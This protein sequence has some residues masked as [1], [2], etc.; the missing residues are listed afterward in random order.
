MNIITGLKITTVYL[1]L[2]LVVPALTVLGLT[3]LNRNSKQRLAQRFGVRSIIYVGGLGVIVHELSHLL[4]AILFGHHIDNFR[5]LITDVQGSNGALGYVNHSWNKKNYYQFMGNTL[6]GTAPIFGC[7]IVLLLLTRFLVPGIYQ[8]GVQYMANLL[9]L[10]FS[11]SIAVGPI[12]WL[13]IILWVILSINVTIGGFDLSDAD[14]KGTVP[15]FVT[16]F[17]ITGV[18]LFLLVILGK[19][20]LIQQC[21]AT[22]L[23]W[24]I[25]IFVL[26]FIWS[27]LVNGLV[28]V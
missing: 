6:I 3:Y 22:L 15:A 1:L 13:F 12:N 26:S 25:L 4:V 2:I 24:F 8:W 23:D 5:L 10:S 21:L 9:G 17:V 20:L 11:P 28:R 14:L 19:A 27:L 16:L 18:L 7:T